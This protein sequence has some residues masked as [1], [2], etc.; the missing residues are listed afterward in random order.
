MKSRITR[1]E[2]TPTRRRLFLASR[3]QIGIN[4]TAAGEETERE[5]GARN[6]PT[7]AENLLRPK[8]FLAASKFSPTNPAALSLSFSFSLFFFRVHRRHQSAAARRGVGENRNACLLP[9]VVA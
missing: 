2:C 8:I 3:Y 5:R 6:E 9:A 7:V 4:P 1:T